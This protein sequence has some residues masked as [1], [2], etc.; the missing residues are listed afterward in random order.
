MIFSLFCALTGVLK[1]FKNSSTANEPNLKLNA[2][3]FISNLADPEKGDFVC[4]NHED[5]F[6]GKH[7][8]IHRLCAEENDT[9]Q[10]INGNVYVNK[11]NIDRKI[12]LIHFYKVSKKEY[13]KIK[14][15]EKIGD[16]NPMVLIDNEN[17]VTLLEDLTAKKYNLEFDRQ[18]DSINKLDKSIFSTYKSN[19]NK[20]NFGPIIIPHGKI[21]VIG[22]NRDNSE[23]SRYIGLIDDSNIVGVLINN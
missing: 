6:A 17:I 5:N 19:W 8:R 14:E 13:L 9:L 12:N 3:M 1:T 22:D 21:F 7:T 18:I 16:N 23:D 10:I 11:V 15:T 4:Y 20:D 2:T